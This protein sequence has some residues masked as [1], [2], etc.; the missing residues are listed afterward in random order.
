MVWA[1][2][3]ADNIYDEKH[4]NIIVTQ[5]NPTFKIKLISNA[6]TG[7]MWFLSDYDRELIEP[8][9]QDY[10]APDSK[11]MGAPA[12]ELWTFK[13]KSSKAPVSQLTSLALVYARPGQK[14]EDTTKETFTI[15][16][17]V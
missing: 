5:D 11:L 4:K 7:Y 3:V 16:V 8:I 6:S 14:P 15:S 10:L 13:L 17:V 12:S 9:K 2:E 1:A